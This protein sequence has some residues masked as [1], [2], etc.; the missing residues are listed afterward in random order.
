[1][2]LPAWAE[3]LC[4]PAW[5]CSL[6]SDKTRARLKDVSGRVGILDR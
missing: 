1:M 4:H 2:L 3:A 5:P 6:G